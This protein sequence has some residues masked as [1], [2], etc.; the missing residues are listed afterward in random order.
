[1]FDKKGKTHARF[2][3]IILY[4]LSSYIKTKLSN[5]TTDELSYYGGLSRDGSAGMTL[6]H[7]AAYKN[8]EKIV[9]FLISKGMDVNARDQSDVTPL[10]YAIKAEHPNKDIV[11][12][13]VSAGADVNAK[14]PHGES[15]LHSAMCFCDKSLDIVKILVLNVAN[16]NAK[17][18]E[19]N[20]P[21]CLAIKYCDTDIADFLRKHGAK[22]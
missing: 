4:P 2:R 3:K 21:L 19:G 10:Y 1:M 14:F 12:S 15:P 5:S 9:L 6:L 11:N 7:Y 16:I 22:E 8:Q 18:E 13:L 17:D 20:T